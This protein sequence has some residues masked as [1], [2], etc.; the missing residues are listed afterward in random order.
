MEKNTPDGGYHYRK[1]ND[2]YQGLHG[3]AA[4]LKEI[5]D[6]GGPN[7]FINKYGSRINGMVE[8]LHKLDQLYKKVFGDVNEF[9]LDLVDDHTPDKKS[10]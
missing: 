8:E 5:S 7:K 4:L 2:N 6:L 3:T 10:D 1:A 9:L